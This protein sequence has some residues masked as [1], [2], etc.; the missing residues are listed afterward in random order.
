MSEVAFIHVFSHF[1]RLQV[2]FLGDSSNLARITR[3]GF[4][5]EHFSMRLFAQ[6]FF[7]VPAFAAPFARLR[8]YPSMLMQVRHRISPGHRHVGTFQV[9]L[10]CNIPVGCVLH[11]MNIHT[12]LIIHEAKGGLLRWPRPQDRRAQSGLRTPAGMQDFLMS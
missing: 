2:C 9:P 12:S 10:S 7:Y 1:H 8:S 5:L 3:F 4:A 11:L 6:T